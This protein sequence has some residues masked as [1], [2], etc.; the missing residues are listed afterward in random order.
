MRPI[1][2]QLHN[3]TV[4]LQDPYENTTDNQKVFR[5]QKQKFQ[6]AKPL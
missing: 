6:Y 4:A 5:I 1:R 2:I 3:C